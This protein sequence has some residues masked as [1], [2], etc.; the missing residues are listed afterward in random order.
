[1]FRKAFS[2]ECGKNLYAQVWSIDTQV[3]Y[4][5]LPGNKGEQ[6]DRKKQ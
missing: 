4:E 3:L 1:M 2:L 5:S 6:V